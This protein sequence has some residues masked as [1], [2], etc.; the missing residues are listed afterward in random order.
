M[1]SSFS[2]RSNV[3][4]RTSPFASSRSG[5]AY[6]QASSACQAAATAYPTSSAIATKP[7]APK[8]ARIKMTAVTLV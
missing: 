1:E 3:M 2:R 5:S 4:Y 7:M 8:A 6:S